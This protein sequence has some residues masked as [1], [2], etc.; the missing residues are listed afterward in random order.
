MTPLCAV[1]FPGLRLES[2]A[3]SQ[4]PRA[5]QDFGVGWEETQGRA[6]VSVSTK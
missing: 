4:Q 2:R 1:A 3:L 5:W 6:E